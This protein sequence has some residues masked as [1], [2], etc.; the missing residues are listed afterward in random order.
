MDILP[1]TDFFNCTA[2]L[3]LVIDSQGVIQ[4]LNPAWQQYL[5]CAATIGQH[6][7]QL[8]CPE[9]LP[10]L[11]NLLTQMQLESS[12][13]VHKCYI[14][15]K[16]QPQQWF[17][18][19]LSFAAGQFYAILT[20]YNNYNQDLALTVQAVGDVF[21]DWHIDENKLY[22]SA[23]WQE[24]LGYEQ[25]PTTIS[26][27][28][29]LIH[30][31]DVAQ[32]E[33]E[34]QAHFNHLTNRYELVYRIKHAHDY[35]IWV[36]D[37]AKASWNAQGHAY[38]LVGSYVDVSHHKYNQHALEE[39]RDFLH[40]IIN[41]IPNPVVVKDYQHRWQL[42]NDAFCE[43]LGYER[44]AIKNLRDE[45]LFSPS[46]AA[47]LHQQDDYVLRTGQDDVREISIINNKQQL[48]TLLIKK[49]R[50]EDRHKR[51]FIVAAITDIT[52]RK[53]AEESLR[54]SEAH[55]RQL[56]NGGND[57][58]LV[59]TYTKDGK[60]SNFIEVNDIACDRFGYTREQLLQL[61]PLQLYAIDD[62][63][64]REQQEILFKNKHVMFE[65]LIYTHNKKTIPNELN[66]H[67]FTLEGELTALAIIR[68]ISE[69]KQAQQALAS[70]EAEYRKLIQHAN[71]IIIRINSAGKISYINIFAEQ[72]FGFQPQD[73]IGQNI[74]GSI[75]PHKTKRWSQQFDLIDFL[76]QPQN[77]AYIENECQ[78][79]YNNPVWI[80]WTTKP[81]YV[82]QQLSEIL[83]IGHDATERKL[84]QDALHERDHLLQSVADITQHLLTTLN[85]DDAICNALE[86]LANLT[87]TDRVYI[88]ENHKHHQTAEPAMSQRFE[89]HVKRHK[90]FIDQPQ[91]Q[92]LPYGAFLPRWYTKLSA[93][94]SIGGLIKDFPK[95]ER[96]SFE[97]KRVVAVL[98]V[99]IIFNDKFWGFIGLDDTKS[100]RIWSNHERFLL[101]AVGDSIR[102]TM[103]R[104]QVEIELHQ[105][106]EQFRTIIQT[107]S[108]G[109]LILDQMGVI[110]FVNP[111]AEALYQMP[112][113]DLIGKKF[114]TIKVI[115]KF[116][117]ENK[118]EVAIPVHNASGTQQRIVEMQLAESEW[119]NAAAYV[120]SLRDITQR[121]QM[122]QALEAQFKRNQLILDSSID[123]F[124]IIDAKQRIIEVNPAFCKLVGYEREVLLYTAMLRL[125]PNNAVS[126]L[127]ANYEQV[128]IAGSGVFESLILTRTQQQI[129]VEISATYV[130]SC[131]LSN[132]SA[133]FSF[134]R[135]IRQRKLA[136]LQLRQAKEQAEAAS[137]AKSEFLATMSH[138]IRTPMN[139]VIGMTDLLIQTELSK[140][141]R[142]YLETIRSS[143]ENLLTII[144]DIL[145][146]SK[147]EAGKL[148]LEY[149][150]FDLQAL[151][152]D[153]INLFAYNVHS[154]D[155]EFN[156][157]LEPIEYYLCGDPTR[158]RQI[159]SNLL[160]N[161]IKFTPKGEINCL[162]KI[163]QQTETQ[164]VIH[165]AVHDT[166]IGISKDALQ[167]LFQP[168]SQADSS[169]TRRYGGTGLGLAIIKHLIELMRG[170]V[171]VYSTEGHGS[172]FFFELP[173]EKI[174]PINPENFAIL[175]NWSKPILLIMPPSHQRE[176]LLSQLHNWR[177]TVHTADRADGGLQLL[178]AA[179]KNRQ[180][181]GLV[182]S[183]FH[184]PLMDGFNLARAVQADKNLASTPCVILTFMDQKL[185][186]EMEQQPFVW[187]V[188]KPLTQ[189]KFSQVLAEIQGRAHSSY[190]KPNYTDAQL[191]GYYIL[192]VE[193]DKI[194]QAVVSDML[195]K[196]GCHIKVAENGLQA[197][198]ILKEQHIDLILMDCHMPEM[199]GFTATRYI[200][201]QNIH[202][203]L[204]IIALTA[205][206]MA[207]DRQLCIQSGMD[208]YLSKP[209]VIKDL[210]AALARWLVTK[211]LNEK[212]ILTTQ[213]TTPYLPVIDD[214][215][216]E[217]LR[218][219]MRGKGLGWIVHL[220]LQELP[221]Y[222]Q[223]IEK[224]AQQH[225]ETAMYQA[226][227]K[228][229]GA[230]VNL[231]A[232][233][234]QALCLNLERLIK[235]GD[236]H[237][238]K[239]LINEQLPRE[240]AQ[241][242]LALEKF[243][244]V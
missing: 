43:L 28:R 128:K 179:G 50:H 71:S 70:Q 89:W 184:A 80:A 194:N 107:N 72:F 13:Q 53:R 171:S 231:G 142:M 130:D 4:Q 166:G 66:I 7:E 190:N 26:A 82:A 99:P 84:A 113:Y 16:F 134:T 167:H 115:P 208:D 178:A 123:G 46:D 64:M 63:Y 226:V 126:N 137:K 56:F 90:L 195:L 106:R 32:V 76:A 49:T 229:K 191:Q 61:T 180:N 240:S 244:H 35:Y 234:M 203:N 81:I 9:E 147:I 62:N 151:L 223:A 85:Y 200:R 160:N 197:L 109:M 205:N 176:T 149:I 125:Y 239:Q 98:L 69:R 216:L 102:G 30:P 68:D 95:Q 207:E 135:D 87:N 221:N 185:S 174:R 177:L 170:T 100:E 25:P 227:H 78:T 210:Y 33:R 101:K 29:A 187:Y 77:Y 169:S 124:C 182:I 204:P 232:K 114:E 31:D 219:E 40:T 105:S 230:C 110:R 133:Y 97:R 175:H 146:F 138:E 165:F 88:Y 164:L 117:Q 119:D 148:T 202:K 41:E 3:L 6:Y 192:V 83:L 27:W 20:I 143:G 12:P 96:R 140:Q 22:F 103:A 92:N 237:T 44:S 209:L 154:K 162:L 145:D 116:D 104:R 228:L 74:L 67:L 186:P 127:L 238:A 91:L 34:L 111:A 236:L 172:Y 153:V 11:Q 206:A 121:K 73:L 118:S 141:Q 18:L 10:T 144:S 152:E 15:L 215:M 79:I 8:I 201:Q 139:G 131:Q 48:R 212:K 241:L 14:R 108:D 156:C 193:D 155:L 94:K 150:E 60:P 213:P 163:Q 159:I 1:T 24:L 45:E 183:D 122:E 57:A 51:P 168:F 218:Y 233:K 224:A 59:H 65:T 235:S 157:D 47:I 188:N 136:E 242:K 189:A 196:L 158:I 243:K 129:E 211:P 38:R 217:T 58:I 2:S 120:I 39:A 19:E 173:L 222:T 161:A 214:Q 225:D 199:D 198:R 132:Q 181:Y 37:R 86:T 75:V 23:T 5:D 93:G 112:Y 36:L 21:W 42:F 17:L 52:E 220:F 54:R 55:Y